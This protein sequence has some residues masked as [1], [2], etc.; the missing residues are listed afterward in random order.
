[1]LCGTADQT[2]SLV[3]QQYEKDGQ[4]TVRSK[5]FCTFLKLLPLYTSLMDF[6]SRLSEVQTFSFNSNGLT[7]VLF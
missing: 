3:I 5:G 4:R 7:K 2:I 1:M 6:K